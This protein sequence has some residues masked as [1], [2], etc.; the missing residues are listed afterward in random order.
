MKLLSLLICLLVIT[1]HVS[2]Q[3]AIKFKVEELSKP[4]KLLFPMAYDD[5]LKHLILA[6][7]SVEP[8]Y[9]R[10][11]MPDYAFNII[12]QSQAPDSLVFYGHQAFFNGMYEA[13]ANHRPFV[14]SPDMIWLLIT[15]GFA[16]HVNA[17]AEALRSNFVDFDGK[18]S[19]VVHSKKDLLSPSLDSKDW[20]AIFPQFTAQ[21]AEYTGK[22]L[23]N[24]LMADF[25][26]TT[27]VEKLASE[28]TIMESMKPYFEF[29]IMRI[30]CGI[31]EIT[32]RGTPDD[33]Q[34]IYDKTKGLAKYDLQWWTNELEPILNEMINTSKGDIDTVFWRNMFKYH[35]G[36]ECG[37]PGTVDGWIVKF[38]PYNKYGKRNNLK[39]LVKGD[40]MPDEV[41]KVD[42]KYMNVYKDSTIATPLELWAGFIGLEQNPVDYTLTPQIA[43]MIRKKE[44]NDVTFIKELRKRANYGLS[45]RVK[46]LP[47]D[48][49]TLKDIYELDVAFIDSIIIPDR[50]QAIPIEKLTLSGK[51]NRLEIE[52]ISKMFPNTALT[53][54]RK[55]IKTQ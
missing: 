10:R 40:N 41:V 35:A 20:E 34:K 46:E 17:N 4:E 12:A 52:R 9:I 36:E 47:E 14:L 27:S 31:P 7:K 42:L 43:W 15:Q 51:T 13:Y 37:E 19:L 25:T 30:V 2:A 22:E 18:L 55:K 11:T 23:L 44:T 53:I 6:D 54:N 28:A 3:Q 38:F 29:V 50:L 21:I 1:N 32:L 33:W 39:E 5:I 16:Q 8:Y 48:I 24:T 26:T 49:Y 45:I